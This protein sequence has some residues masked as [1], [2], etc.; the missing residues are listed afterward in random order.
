MDR[1]FVDEETGESISL[2]VSD[3]EIRQ[4][5]VAVN[6]VETGEPEIN[7]IGTETTKSRR[8]RFQV[9]KLILP[10]NLIKLLP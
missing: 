2:P 5:I 4:H 9:Q 3:Y 7:V 1:I 8:M 10:R 6:N